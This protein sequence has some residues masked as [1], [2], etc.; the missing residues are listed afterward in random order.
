MVWWHEIY[1]NGEEDA[2]PAE[3]CKTYPRTLTSDGSEQEGS[4]APLTQT[5]RVE[6]TESGA[7]NEDKNVDSSTKQHKFTTANH[8]LLREALT[9]S[10]DRVD[11]KKSGLLDTKGVAEALETITF[12]GEQH[13]TRSAFQ[14]FFY[15]FNFQSS[16]I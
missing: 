15:F 16:F 9:I 7:K 3:F 10:F 12:E 2:Y 8:E 1:Q 6:W 5:V 14:D 11:R 4:Q 13:W